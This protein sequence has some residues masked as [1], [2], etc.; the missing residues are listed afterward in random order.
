MGNDPSRAD[1]RRCVRDHVRRIEAVRRVGIAVV[2][3]AHCRGRD[4]GRIAGETG[5]E[6]IVG[7]FVCS[8]DGGFSVDVAS[9]GDSCGNFA[10]WA[11]HKDF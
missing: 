6:V 4:V 11:F 9:D 5:R 10:G 1:I 7:R 8:T 3:S 2:R